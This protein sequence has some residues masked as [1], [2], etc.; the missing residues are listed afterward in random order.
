MTS[1]TARKFALI[2]DKAAELRPNEIAVG[3]T[4]DGQR[5][6]LTY[7]VEPNRLIEIGTTLLGDKKISGFVNYPGERW[8][9]K[10]P[11]R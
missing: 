7:R 8:V 11:A 4:S 1:P 6:V 10:C 2:F 9:N 5:I 3:G